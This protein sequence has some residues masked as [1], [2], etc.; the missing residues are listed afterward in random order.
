MD[1]K[2]IIQTFVNA[3]KSGKLTL[4]DVPTTYKVQVELILNGGEQSLS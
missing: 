2:V 1:D 4:N 3:I